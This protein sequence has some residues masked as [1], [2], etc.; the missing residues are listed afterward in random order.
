MPAALA[1]PFALSV[2]VLQGGLMAVD[3][4][5]FHRRRA[6]PRWERIGHPLDTLTV[7]VPALMAATLPFT[8]PW[9]ALFV[10]L[11]IFSC[12]FVTK[13]EWI[14]ARHCAPAEHWLHA[15]LF[16]LHPMLF[17]ALFLLWR[18]GETGWIA[19]QAA[20]TALF[21]AWQTLY[22]NGPWAPRAEPL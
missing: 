1:I 21:L 15:L 4:F 20:L 18:A 16:I 17:A 14:H 13:D 11:A 5:S 19:G 22:W 10:A 12:L 8:A 9:T 2:F 7:L 6:M 3:E